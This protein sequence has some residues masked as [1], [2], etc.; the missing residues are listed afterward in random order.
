MLSVDFIN[1]G[2][3]DSILAR[4]TGEGERGP[5]TLLID[6]GDTNTGAAYPNSCR[7]NA[8]DFLKQEGVTEIDVLLLTHLHRDHIGGLPKIIENT[9]VKELWTNYI[10]D[11]PTGKTEV[12]QGTHWD[13]AGKDTAFSLNLYLDILE[14]LRATGTIFRVLNS[15]VTPSFS[16]RIGERFFI[17]CAFADSIL[18]RRQNELAADIFSRKKNTV[19]TKDE[20]LY[21][22]I[23]NLNSILNDSSI[24]V[25][26]KHKDTVIAL[27]GDVSAS[28]WLRNQPKKCTV[29][30]IPHHGHR[31]GMSE[32]LVSFLRPEYFVLSVSN[33][34]KDAC[35]HSD[36]VAIIKKYAKKCFVTDA[37][38][39]PLVAEKKFH[40]S[41]RFKFEDGIIFAGSHRC[42]V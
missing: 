39:I 20:Y 4:D 22:K 26:L 13:D 28:S 14:K 23:K 29:L 1:V 40:S 19:D 34:R 16:K 10:P 42:R 21:N 17:E 11:F 38:S 18:Y 36:S 5:F 9:V 8:A 35:P 25:T 7:I 12:R 37:L 15:T 3:G 41:V 24:R 30:K 2:Y 33:D 32:E 6:S 31:D 27:P